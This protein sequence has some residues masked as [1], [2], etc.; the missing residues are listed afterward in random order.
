MP[1][2]SNLI[3]CHIKSPLGSGGEDDVQRQLRSLLAPGHSS[4]SEGGT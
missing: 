3:L 2:V 1:D 4:G